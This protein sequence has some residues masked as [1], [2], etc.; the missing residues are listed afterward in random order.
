MYST[1]NGIVRTSLGPVSSQGSQERA[2]IEEPSHF[3]PGSV[4][5]WATVPET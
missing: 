3:G 2:I 4:L 5:L 1:Y